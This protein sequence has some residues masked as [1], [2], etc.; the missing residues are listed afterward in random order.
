MQVVPKTPRGIVTETEAGSSGRGASVKSI[1]AERLLLREYGRLASSY[2]RWSVTASPV[3]WKE[4]R[5]VVPDLRSQCALDLACGTGAHAVRLARAVGPDGSVVGI[6]A[7]RGMVKYARLRPDARRQSNLRFLRMNS[8]SLR[9]PSD[10]FDLVLSTFGF[11]L[12]GRSQCLREILRV[13]RSGGIFVYTGWHGAN[14]EAKAFA[15]VMRDLRERHPSSPY[16][17]RLTRAREW[18]S[19]L[20]ENRS[21]L[22]TELRRAGFRQVRRVLK[23]VSIRF[24]SPDAYVRY[25]ATWGE[26]ERELR[27]LNPADRRKFVQQVARCMKWSRGRGG[28]KVTWE[29]TFISASKPR[30]GSVPPLVEQPDHTT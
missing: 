4:V 3:V 5:K 7:A 1:E 2:D 24:R 26:Y 25:K 14:R 27:R 21:T 16:G 29:L 9:F 6:D 8:R 15:A 12:F 20:P 22:V 30:R 28:P 19:Q 18:V 11:A 23:P 10:T 13:L 17:R